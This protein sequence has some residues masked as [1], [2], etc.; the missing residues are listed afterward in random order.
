MKTIWSGGTVVTPRGDA[1]AVETEHGK[2][3]RVFY[4]EFPTQ[5]ANTEYRDLAGCTLMPSFL[6]AHSHLTAFA[7]TLD[8]APLAGSTG[9][10]E[11]VRR[12]R[13]Y[14]EKTGAAPGDWIKG[15]GYDQNLLG[16]HPTARELDKAFPENPVL[17]THASGHMGVCNTAGLRALGVTPDTEAPQG[18]VIGRDASGGLTGYLEEAAFIS[19]SA[20]LPPPKPERM[21]ELIAQAQNV[22]FSYGVTTIQEGMVRAS[23]QA[24]LERARD[25]G[26]LRCDVMAYLDLQDPVPLRAGGRLHNAGYKIFLDGSPQGGTAWMTQ[27]YEDGGNGY[28]IHSDERVREFVRRAVRDGR[29]LLAHCN[30]DAACEQFL[31]AC[32]AE[33][34]R[35][36]RPVMIHAQL[37]R[38]DQLA[39]MARI[40]MIP[41]FFVAHTRYWGDTHLKNFGAARANLISPCGTAQA[42]G[43]PYTLHQD[44]P[45]LPPDML[46]TVQCAVCRMTQAGVLL[47]P[48]ERITTQQALH[49]VTANAAYQYFAEREKGAIAE[50]FRADLV[51]L[52]HDVRTV[53][54]EEIARVSVVET[55]CDGE[56]VFR[57]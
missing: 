50:G 51:V 49:A 12:L 45:V 7:N 10:E 22:Y 30:G 21:M 1:R 23:E 57:R 20:K 31:S 53:P 9:Q 3:T 35:A 41:S 19:F 8:L 43:L 16:A 5:Q 15:F 47:G 26:I 56:T 40:G 33:D 54:P 14:A 2:I 46:D 6:D 48:E 55:I 13:D 39:R 27:P 36:L 38:R 34:V 52:S 11:L 4:D 18:G 25:A 28:A 29:Q 24:L 32:E 37:V 44:S 17:L 42:L